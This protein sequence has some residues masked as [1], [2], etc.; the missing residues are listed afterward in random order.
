MYF[1]QRNPITIADLFNWSV[2]AGWDTFWIQGVQNYREELEFYE[3]LT[4]LANGDDNQGSESMSGASN[5][6]V[7]VPDDE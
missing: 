7:T 2:E 4:K 3:M 1:G 6:P 5:D